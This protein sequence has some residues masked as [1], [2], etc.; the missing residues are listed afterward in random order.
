MVGFA[1]IAPLVVVVVVDDPSLPSPSV[2]PR[3]AEE[4]ILRDS[5]SNGYEVLVVVVVIVL[6]DRGGFMFG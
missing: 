1:C 2:L 3:R 5:R 4:Y 6:G